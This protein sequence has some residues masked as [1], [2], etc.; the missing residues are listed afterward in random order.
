MIYL[1]SFTTLLNEEAPDTPIYRIF[2]DRINDKEFLNDL[3][4]TSY[5]YSFSNDGI[6][7][8]SGQYLDVKVNIN[9]FY[10]LMSENELIQ[11]NNESSEYFNSDDY[12][13]NPPFANFEY[14]A[15]YNKINISK[16]VAERIKKE[17]EIVSQMILFDIENQCCELPY[18]IKDYQDIKQPT[19]F[20]VNVDENGVCNV[21]KKPSKVYINNVYNHKVVYQLCNLP[22]EYYSKHIIQP[23]SLHY[24]YTLNKF[25]SSLKESPEIENQIQDINKNGLM[26]P[27]VLKINKNGVITKLVNCNTRFI[28]A[29][30]LKL[31]EIPAVLMYDGTNDITSYLSNYPLDNDYCKNYLKNNHL[32]LFKEINDVK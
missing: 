15:K 18:F 25:I 10:T 11:F 9:D 31:P 30:Y 27:L 19:Y 5:N 8:C 6:Y 21:F 24:N 1:K 16:E 20:K 4:M 17:K 32:E 7:C 23:C 13:D 22:Y 28:S 26:L 2:Q 12:N 14:W 3:D 29:Y